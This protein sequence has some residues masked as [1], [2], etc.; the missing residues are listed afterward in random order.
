MKNLTFL[1]FVIVYLMFSSIK[2]QWEIQNE[3]MNGFLNTMDFTNEVTGWIAGGEYSRWEKALL[4]KTEDG[5]DTWFQLQIDGDFVIEMID[6][7]NDSVGWVI[8]NGNSFGYILKT[9][10]GGQ[11]W[12]RQKITPQDLTLRS[13]QIINDSVGYITGRHIILKTVNGGTDWI[14]ISPQNSENR[15][16]EICHFFNSQTGLVIGYIMYNDWI[17]QQSVILRTD[18]GGMTW[19]ETVVAEFDRIITVQFIDDST[20]FFSAKESDQDSCSLYKTTDRLRNW[21]MINQSNNI[22]SFFF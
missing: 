4:L 9:I 19:E 1:S 22:R 7:I 18:N 8:G 6:F 2:G 20:G 10:D 17:T 12:S 3:G 5:G 15:I 11:S 16:Y 14:D 21:S 13:I